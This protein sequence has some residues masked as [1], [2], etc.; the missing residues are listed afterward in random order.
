[1]PEGCLEGTA[2]ILSYIKNNKP[3]NNR[4]SSTMHYNCKIIALITLVAFVTGCTEN[5]LPEPELL[6]VTVSASSEP[7]TRAD[8]TFVNNNFTEGKRMGVFGYTYTS[9]WQFYLLPDFF[10][11]QPMT[12]KS[13]GSL[14]YSPLRYWPSGN[15]KVSLYAYYPYD[16][17]VSN[18]EPNV[19]YGMGTFTYTTP[20]TASAQTDFMV[21]RRLDNLTSSSGT[22]NLRFYQVLAC[23]E[24]NVNLTGSS[25]KQIKEVKVTN[26]WTKGRFNPYIMNDDLNAIPV[27][28]DWRTNAWPEEFMED[29]QDMVVTGELH[30]NTSL[31]AEDNHLYKLLVIPQR[32][33]DGLMEIQLTMVSNTDVTETKTYNLYDYTSS[34]KWEAGKR[35]S[36]TVTPAP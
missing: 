32:C 18:I 24:I 23:I 36:Y 12:I 3:Q 27:S 22:V 7:L 1:M 11:N 6:P 10:N 14:S 33:I 35:Y 29:R 15:K 4:N 26:V 19:N 2:S 21:T 16:G 5:N 30:E 13:A 28:D 31:D 20:T 8:D 34:H 17:D 25:Y 9:S